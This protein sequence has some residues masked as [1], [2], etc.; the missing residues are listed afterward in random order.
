MLRR[1][2]TIGLSEVG[3]L[4][5]VSY[6]LAVLHYIVRKIN[7]KVFIF[8]KAATSALQKMDTFTGAIIDMIMR[9]AIMTNTSGKQ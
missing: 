9:T 4:L 1:S 3:S 6:S 5:F 7:V 2:H 8:G